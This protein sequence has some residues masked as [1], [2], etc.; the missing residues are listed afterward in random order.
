M[1]ID[2]EHLLL[3]HCRMV[4][5]KAPPVRVELQERAGPSS[6]GVLC[7]IR[8]HYEFC[9]A[10]SA[11]RPR[12]SAGSVTRFGRCN[13]CHRLVARPTQLAG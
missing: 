2:Y 4:A 9:L 6:Y 1:L 10:P 8:R 11:S 13:R 7:R 12:L 5:A 3:K